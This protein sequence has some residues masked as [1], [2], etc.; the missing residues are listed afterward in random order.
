MTNYESNEIRRQVYL[1]WYKNAEVKKLLVILDKANAEIAKKLLK[2][3][4]V[5]TK[6]RYAEI[7]KFLSKLSKEA[8]HLIENGFEIDEL[9]EAELLA[10]KNILKKALARNDMFL[11]P[12]AKQVKNAVLFTPI[13]KGVTFKAFMDS[14]GAR[15]YNVWDSYVRTGYL[16]GM[17][18]DE[19]VR[20]VLGSNKEAGAI[21]G[22]RRSV[23]ANTRT[24]LQSFAAETRNAVYRENEAFFWGYKWL[25][26]LD[27]RTCLICG[28]LDGKT[29]KSI[30]E[31]PQIPAH[32][33]CRCLLIPEVKG[34][35]YV[36]ERAAMAGAV[37]G[38][39]TYEQW[40]KM[41]TETVQKEILGTAR[42]K[43]YKEGMPI[44]SF[45]AGEKILTIKELKKRYNQL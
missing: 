31:A 1:E 2:T 24:A 22:L 28:K 16:T 36:G 35:D 11:L 9:I 14:V 45:V 20:Q 25:A 33:Q 21:A 13:V 6:R 41:Q 37:K 40:L 29:F 10:Q 43:M 39:T 15:M 32:T 12:A 19:I 38:D 7:S 3:R 18:T 26:T 17:T 42:Y 23:E 5:Y 4:G 27:T 34:P 30:D 8:A 44:T